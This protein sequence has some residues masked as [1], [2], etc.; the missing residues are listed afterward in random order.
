M[1]RIIG[2][3]DDFAFEHQQRLTIGVCTPQA[4]YLCVDT[5]DALKRIAREP[6]Y[7]SEKG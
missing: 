4:S 5:I 1:E 3:D 6:A 7:L 2:M